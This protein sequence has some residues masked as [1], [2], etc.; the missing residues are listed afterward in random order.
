M[1]IFMTKNVKEFGG[2]TNKERGLNSSA[3][4]S[5]KAK[6]KYQ[7]SCSQQVTVNVNVNNNSSSDNYGFV[8]IRYG[9]NTMYR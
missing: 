9:G 1:V 3:F 6:V 2:T 4:C 5:P 7:R 8:D